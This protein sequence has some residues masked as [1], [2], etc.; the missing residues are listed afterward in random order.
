MEQIRDLLASTLCAGR[1][2]TSLLANLV[3]LKKPPIGL[4]LLSCRNAGLPS[5]TK[6]IARW[7][8]GC[9]RLFVL[10]TANAPSRK[11][12]IAIIQRGKYWGWS[13]CIGVKCM[14]DD[15][16]AVL[17]WREFGMK[18]TYVYSEDVLQ[19]KEVWRVRAGH[20]EHHAS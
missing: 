11:A 19:Q 9:R 17:I 18:D 1:V 4:G 3:I 16:A 6:I 13:L 14:V 12:W 8:R 7:Y 15:V 20:E 5:R 10:W 2:S